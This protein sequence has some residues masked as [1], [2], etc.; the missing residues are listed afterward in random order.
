M[1]VT[2]SG[3]WRYE[4][5]WP[6]KKTQWTKFHL[7]SWGRLME[8]E[9]NDRDDS[10]PDCFVQEPLNVTSNVKSVK[11]TTAA[12]PKDT[13]VIGPVAIYWN[14]AI[15]QEDTTW[16]VRLRDLDQYGNIVPICP[17]Q[18]FDIS[19][20]SW[21]RASFRTLDKKRS[22]PWKPWHTYQRDLC[23]PGEIYENA[24]SLDATSH[25]FKAGHRIQIE[26]CC[27]D[28]VPGY[29]HLCNAKTTLHKIYHT[30]KYPSYLLLPIIPD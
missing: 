5:E 18:Q 9:P 14:A 8:E 4:N 7:R 27:M 23:K 20:R 11:Y 15:D 24:L 10:E 22:E 21:I 1:Y 30:S 25:C 3:L 19:D 6:L 13:N 17:P 28:S 16:N 29:L 12:L 2:G 26:I